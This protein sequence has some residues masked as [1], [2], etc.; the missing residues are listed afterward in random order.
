MPPILDASDDLLTDIAT[1]GVADRV[2][3]SCFSNHV[4]FVHIDAVMWQTRLDPQYLKRIVTDRTRTRGLQGVP[5]IA[6]LVCIHDKVKSV[7]SDMCCANHGDLVCDARATRL[8][9]RRGLAQN[10]ASD[11][12]SL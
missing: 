12:S 6:R 11:I 2:V 7:F 3:E 5:Q 8:Y 4:G 10:R 1:L 9:C